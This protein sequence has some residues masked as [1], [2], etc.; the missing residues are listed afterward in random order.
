MIL[1]WVGLPSCLFMAFF[2][3]R[4][5]VW[6]NIL[7]LAAINYIKQATIAYVLSFPPFFSPGTALVCFESKL[8]FNWAIAWTHSTTWNFNQIWHQCEVF[9]V[10]KERSHFTLS[11]FRAHFCCR[12]QSIRYS[13]AIISFLQWSRETSFELFLQL[14]SRDSCFIQAVE[15]FLVFKKDFFLNKIQNFGKALF[16]QV[17][18]PVRGIRIWV[19]HE[20]D[21]KK[22]SN[23]KVQI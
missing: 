8:M 23:F 22:E 14:I 10:W 12:Q 20:E 4:M 3:G 13:R 15:N 7:N 11:N 9:S 19:I 18:N 21:L 6:E 1:N 2:P 5:K 16:E 17:E